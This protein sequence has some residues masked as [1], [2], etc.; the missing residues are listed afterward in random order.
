MRFGIRENEAHGT[1][2]KRLSGL[3]VVR[4]LAGLR[5]AG[6]Q[7]A[8]R[9][10]AS[11]TIASLTVSG[12]TVVGLLGAAACLGAAATAGAASGQT[13]AAAPTGPQAELSQVELGRG[14]AEMNCSACH[15]LGLNDRSPMATA[16]AFRDL[17]RRY[18]VEQLEE[19]LAEGIVA[20]HEN[21]P[22][23]V[24]DPEEIDAFVA[25]LKSLGGPAAR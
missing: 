1:D 9:T 4:R 24:L 19:S 10:I 6:R 23:L 22:E 21:M 11:L 2:R 13:L 3:A 8:G 16:P 17:W 20:G 5:A 15:A 14:I 12:L 25:Y 7:G 18:P